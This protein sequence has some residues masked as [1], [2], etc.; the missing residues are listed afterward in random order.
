MLAAGITAALGAM[1]AKYVPTIKDLKAN[2]RFHKKQ[3]ASAQAKKA[4]EAQ[5]AKTPRAK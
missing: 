3:V 1:G 4:S 5:R 2:L